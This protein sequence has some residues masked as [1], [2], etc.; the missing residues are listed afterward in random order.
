M[1]DLK[2]AL[3]RAR[4]IVLLLLAV[5]ARLL[6]IGSTSPQ[7]SIA[8][9]DAWGYHR[10]ALNLDMGNGFSL[11]REAPFVPDS[12][13]TPLY[14]AFLWLIRQLLGPAP[15]LA[16][17]IQAMIDGCT[18][19]LTWWLATRLGGRRAGRIAALFYALNSTQIRYTNELLTETLLS[20]L[21]ALSTCVLVKYVLAVSASSRGETCTAHL[22][23]TKLVVAALLCGLAILCKPNVLFLPLIWLL[24]LV[25]VHWQCWQRAL[26]DTALMIASIAVVLTP[27]I[28]RNYLVFGRS[29]LSTAFEGNISRVS[30]PATLL[31]VSGQYA[32]PWSEE[33]EARFGEIVTVAA[34]RYDWSKPWESLSAGE[35]DAHN[36]QVYV[37]AQ[38][39]LRQHPIAWLSSHAQGM[40]R[41]LEPQTYRVCYAQFAGRGWPPDILEDA[42][43]HVI[44]E[45]SAGHWAKAG[46][47]VATER[48]A[49]LDTAQRVIWW[50]TF[51]GQFLGLR[52]M[53]RGTWRLLRHHPSLALTLLLTTAYVL[54]VPGPIAYERFR[55]PVTSLI[56]ALIGMSCSPVLRQPIAHAI[57]VSHAK[58]A[59]AEDEACESRSPDTEASSARLYS[60]C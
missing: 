36:R 11:R 5:G 60:K 41:Y 48:W 13:R 47:I 59:G 10:L 14:P 50:G 18:T 3:D 8:S 27:W 34:E 40:G 44:R 51:V 9:V 42:A 19:A 28:A 31:A 20:L 24:A 46:E 6:Y 54:W 26:A 45:I 17:L 56:M 35:L 33:W 52:L 53:L 49:K 30:A 4:P 2:P 1:N 39:I 32:N 16:A 23:K 15:R 29:F 38:E 55:V 12:I 58:E 57:I 7:A 37:V 22:P 43:V 21:L 25:L